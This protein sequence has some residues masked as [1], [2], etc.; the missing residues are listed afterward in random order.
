MQNPEISPTN[1]QPR[2]QVAFNII[3]TYRVQ[4]IRDESIAT[5][6]IGSVVF[7]FWVQVQRLEDV[8]N[9]MR[10]HWEVHMQPVSGQT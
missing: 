9:F 8:D 4:Y 5:A 3:Y 7:F 10:Q 1:S 6:Y 2:F